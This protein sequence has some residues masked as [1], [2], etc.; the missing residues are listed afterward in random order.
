M[1]TITPVVIGDLTKAEL[2][3]D[4]VFDILMRANKAHLEDQFTQNRIKGPE[5]S[6]VYLGS[7]TQV[8]NAALQFL[9]Q[10]DKL[11]LEAQLIEQQILLAQVEVQKAQAELAIITASLPK[12]A[13]EIALLEQQK[14]NLQDELLTSAKQRLKLEQETANLLTQN[15]LIAQQTA[16]AVIEATVLTAQE[17]KLRAEYDV[18]ILNKDKTIA[19]STLLAQKVVTERAQT[20]AAGVDADSVIGKQKNLYSAQTA[21]YS[22][23]AEQKAVKILIDTWSVRRTTD[24]GTVADATNKLDDVTIG[25]AVTKMLAGINS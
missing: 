17:C 10:K 4:G 15:G 25:A 2:S 20:V 24:E 8:L 19:E 22:R 9:L 16:N 12:V 1:P 23:D 21:G 3:G 5:Y 11:A 13:A 7:L 6:T 14:L 18:L